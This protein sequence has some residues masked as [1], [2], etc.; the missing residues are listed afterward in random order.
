MARYFAGN[1]LAAFRRTASSIVESTTAGTFDS[2][3]VGNSILVPGYVFLETPR[4]DAG[5]L[6][7]HVEV[8]LNAGG[9]SSGSFSVMEWCDSGGTAR[10]RLLASVGGAGSTITFQY[11]N[12]S[13]WVAVGAALTVVSG[14]TQFDFKIVC[15]AS[16]TVEWYQNSAL[17]RNGTFTNSSS[18]TIAYVRF[19]TTTGSSYWSQILG[20]DFDTRDSRYQMP[21]IN[22]AGGATDGTG[23]Y[24]DVNETVLSEATAAFVTAVGQNRSFTHAAITVPGGYQIGAACVSGRVRDDESVDVALGFRVNGT[25]YPTDVDS[26]TGYEPRTLMLETN[27]DT[28]AAWDQTT[29]NNAEPLFGAVAA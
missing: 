11:F 3:Y 12:A 24:T 19:S 10:F 7:T 1:T 13:A 8:Q 16:G 21:L 14:R 27:P 22:G 25:N 20:A 9:G 6:W 26:S 29:Y 4:F 5:T 18:S 17:I 2:T 15:G 23:A 28:A